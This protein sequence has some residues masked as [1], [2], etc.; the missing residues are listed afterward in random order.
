MF[1]MQ[2]IL[3]TFLK[4]LVSNLLCSNI[5]KVKLYKLLFEFNLDGCPACAN[6]QA[7]FED[8]AK[9]FVETEPG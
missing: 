1:S 5:L 3:L 7:I 8:L 6:F 2:P 4:N 9:T